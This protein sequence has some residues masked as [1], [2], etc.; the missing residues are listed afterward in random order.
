MKILMVAGARPNFMKIAPIMRALDQLAEDGC[1][2]I[3][4]IKAKI[5]HTGQHYDDGMSETF[6]RDLGIPAPDFFLNVGSGSH[7]VQ[8]TRI[9]TAFEEICDSERPDW[10]VVVGD[11]NS[12][13]ACAIVAKKAGIGVAHVEAGLRSRDM[14][15]PEEINR[16]VTDS[17]SDLFFVTEKS[18]VDNLL[19]EGKR[20]DQIHFVGHVMVDNLLHQ[21]RLLESGDSSRF[22]VAGMKPTPK[23]YA[24]LTL[25]RPANVDDHHTFAGIA[26]ALNTIAETY[27][28]FFPV[29]PRTRKQ[30]NVFG[31]RL[32]DQITQLPPLGFQESLYL[33]KDAALVLTDS[34]GL[35]EETTALGIPCLTLRDNTERPVTIEEGTNV[36]AGTTTESILTAY[37]SFLTGGGKAGRVP[38]LWDGRAAERIV[39]VLRRQ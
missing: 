37:K 26:A 35:Q 12:T 24:F 4:G 3:S 29:H 33:W 9:M 34:G 31:I 20:S 13:L 21:M 17:I 6:F 8:T 2:S 16:I 22:V 30:L 14:T 10:V 18:G 27:P 32:S 39:G 15:M 23:T 7:A 28:I 25:H 19:Y 1:Q 5:V 36:L 38:E 11:V